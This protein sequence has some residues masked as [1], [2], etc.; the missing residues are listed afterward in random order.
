MS[1]RN[2]HC[3][4][5][6]RPTVCEYISSR[7][8]SST[9]KVQKMTS[10]LLF[11]TFLDTLM[12][13]HREVQELITPIVLS[14]HVKSCRKWNPSLFLHASVLVFMEER[15]KWRNIY[16]KAHKMMQKINWRSFINYV[17]IWCYRGRLDVRNLEHT[18]FDTCIHFVQACSSPHH[19]G[20]NSVQKRIG[21][22]NVL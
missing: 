19:T 4:L 12:E 9:E 5:F 14:K 6:I 10:L 11:S 17:I 20:Y 22:P 13:A 21:P 7:L 8:Y 3:M 18:K 15:R 2:L 16:M 1:Y